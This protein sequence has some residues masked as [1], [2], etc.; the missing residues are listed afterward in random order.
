VLAIHHEG[1]LIANPPPD[2][3]L[4]ENDT[5]VVLGPSEELRAIAED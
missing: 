1:E 3:R 4:E 2:S 5:I